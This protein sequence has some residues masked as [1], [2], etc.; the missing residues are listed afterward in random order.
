MSK[1]NVVYLSGAITKNPNYILDF[2]RAESKLKEAIKYGEYDFTSICN[3]ALVN[4]NLPK[5]FKH[6]DYMRVCFAM[7]DCCD[8]IYMLKGW[9]SSKG[10]K[11]ELIYAKNKGMSI[12]YE[13]LSDG[14]L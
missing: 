2:S 5:D 13:N 3:P 1:R 10:A 12:Y 6:K 4:A 8:S 7:M 14:E 9:E 11:Q